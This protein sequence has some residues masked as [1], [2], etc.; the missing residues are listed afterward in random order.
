MSSSRISIR[1]LPDTDTRALPSYQKETT[2]TQ[3]APAFSVAGESELV[4]LEEDFQKTALL[5]ASTI[6]ESNL[7][8]HQRYIAFL[9]SSH[10]PRLNDFIQALVSLLATISYVYGLYHDGRPLLWWPP[11]WVRVFDWV[12]LGFSVFDLAFSMSVTYRRSLQILHGRALVAMCIVIP[13]VLIYI[14]APEYDAY[15]QVLLALLSLRALNFYRLLPFVTEPVWHEVA[16]ISVTVFVLVLVAASCFSA[17]EQLAW[18]TAGYFV[19]ATIATVGYGDVIP[20]TRV[21]RALVVVTIAVSFVV[22]LLEAVLL[23]NL[24]TKRLTAWRGQLGRVSP[25]RHVL[26]LGPLTA[27]RA[28]EFLLEFYHADRRMHSHA[29]WLVALSPDEPSAEIQQLLL[30]TRVQRR[31]QL[32]QGSPLR[33]TDLLR[34]SIREARAAMVF[35]GNSAAQEREAI[36]SAIAVRLLCPTIP[37]LVQLPRPTLRTFLCGLRCQAICASEFLPALLA[38][39]VDCPGLPTLLVGLLGASTSPTGAPA[40]LDSNS[41]GATAA[42]AAATP[43]TGGRIYRHS[44]E[45][46]RGVLDAARTSGSIARHPSATVSARERWQCQFLAGHDYELFH[47]FLA[48]KHFRNVTFLDAVLHLYRQHGMLLLALQ[49]PPRAGATTAPLFA[50]YPGHEY[51]FVGDE[52]VLLLARNK[53]DVD[54][55]FPHGRLPLHQQLQESHAAA[56][57]ADVAH[58][59]TPEVVQ[60]NLY[61]EGQHRMSFE[62]RIAFRR[63]REATPSRRAN[64]VINSSTVSSPQFTTLPAPQRLRAKQLPLE[65]RDHIVVVVPTPHDDEQ[66]EDVLLSLRRR[67]AQEDD[68]QTVRVCVRPVAILCMSR[69]RRDARYAWL[70]QLYWVSGSGLSWADLM[71][72]ALPR[73]HSV[74]ILPSMIVSNNNNNNSDHNVDDSFGVLTFRNIVEHIPAPQLRLN[75]CVALSSLHNNSPL[76]VTYPGKQYAKLQSPHYAAGMVCDA[77]LLDRFTAQAFYNPFLPLFVRHFL[78]PA[79]STASPQ[80]VSFGVTVLHMLPL[81]Q[82]FSGQRFDVLLEHQMRQRDTLVLALYRQPHPVVDDAYFPYVVTNPPSDLLLR[83]DDRIFALVHSRARLNPPSPAP[84]IS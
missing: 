79:P 51:V 60:T 53:D 56:A 27:H 10:I 71:R 62:Q 70:P 57:S 16:R 82:G 43:S 3:P 64:D 83:D 63:R 72:V 26:L 80:S 37:L 73:A 81:P 44:C 48:Q 41:V 45:A 9:S 1:V 35:C 23:G 77:G 39:T 20:H 28:V 7:G 55:V 15:T 17:C 2:P 47:V 33:E 78:D 50:L 66:L 34:V 12:Q 84:V 65:I 42:D 25:G 58:Y 49:V 8:W 76:C 18:G 68:E 36:L 32:F 21:G 22:L 59:R 54:R 5:I 4:L 31:L 40:Y 19:V 61:S 11:L 38:R 74:L 46:L 13:I 6:D 24:L 69:P 30:R 52:V 29:F 14:Q 67:Y 75:V